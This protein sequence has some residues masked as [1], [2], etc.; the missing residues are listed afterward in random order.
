MAIQLK[1]GQKI[2]L[3]KEKKGLSRVIVGLGWD[4]AKAESNNKGF[5]S[6]LFSIFTTTF[7]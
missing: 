7:V 2:N 1:K 6:S 5:F 4:E 3:S